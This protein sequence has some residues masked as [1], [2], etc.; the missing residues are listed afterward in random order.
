[1][2]PKKHVKHG[3]EEI[4]Y[5][6]EWEFR[7]EALRWKGDQPIGP[8]FHPIAGEFHKW[9]QRKGR[10][11][12]FTDEHRDETDSYTNPYTYHASALVSILA[13][14][15][16]DSH[17]IATSTD[18]VDPMNIEIARVRN[19]N[20]QALYIAR[21]CE[22]LTKQLLFCTEIPLR[23]YKGASLGQLLSTE[24]RGC[25]SSGQ[26]RHKLSYLGSL[27]HRYGLCGKFEQC[28]REHMKIVGRRRNVDAAHSDTPTLD[29]R[30]SKESREQLKADTIE[31]GNEFIHMLEHLNEIEDHM[32]SELEAAVQS[33]F[34]DKLNKIVTMIGENRD[35]HS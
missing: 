3:D 2:A 21:V 17:S 16:N 19:Y 26:K 24:C 9:L 20:E 1:M 5:H 25:R 15:I 33:H 10:F 29:V 22:S 14:I 30:S 8:N 34:I 12:I 27:A 6:I 13:N 32:N 23:H 4:A 31:L 28:L 7:R 18:V 35:R 11:A